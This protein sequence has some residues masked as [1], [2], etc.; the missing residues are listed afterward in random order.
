MA[1]YIWPIAGDVVITAGW[2]Y[3]GGGLHRA[4]DVR[5]MEGTPVRAMADGT[6]VW[7][8]V[9]DGKTK[10]GNMSYGTAV[11]IRHDDGSFELLAHFKNLAPGI[12]YGKK[13]KQGEI[14]GYSGNTG[15]S[16]GPHLHIEFRAW[17]NERLHPLNFL[18]EPYQY[19]DDRVAQGIGPFTAP[20][21]GNTGT[22]QNFD[23]YR[24]TIGPVSA[25]DLTSIKKLCDGLGNIA[26]TVETL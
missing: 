24:M 13:V 22:P 1:E 14:I 17:G 4:I 15:N 7:R 21:S 18:P 16:T 8:Q 5:A 9:W 19:K 11:K 2:Y 25:G 10:S 20:E 3:P 26:Y 23:L 12:V 6:V